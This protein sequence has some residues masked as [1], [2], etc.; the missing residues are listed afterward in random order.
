MRSNLD[1][2]GTFEKYLEEGKRKAFIEQINVVVEWLYEAGETASKD[3]YAKK[4]K[5]FR[6]I[7][8]PVK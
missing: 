5:E 3:E 1:S 7:G 8:D 4:L 2:Y 6:S